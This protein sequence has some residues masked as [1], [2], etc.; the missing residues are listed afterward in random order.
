MLKKENF[1]NPE[2]IQ[3]TRVNW[4]FTNLGSKGHNLRRLYAKVE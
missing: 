2:F 4:S 1:G 3:K